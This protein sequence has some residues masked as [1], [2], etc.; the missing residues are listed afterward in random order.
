MPPTDARSCIAAQTP[1]TGTLRA[2]LPE[3]RACVRGRPGVAAPGTAA[4]RS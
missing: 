4:L 3:G 1:S 2:K